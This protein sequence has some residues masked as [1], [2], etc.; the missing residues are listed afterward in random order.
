MFVYLLSSDVEKQAGSFQKRVSGEN[1]TPKLFKE[2]WFDEECE[3]LLQ[4]RQLAY[5]KNSKFSSCQNCSA[6]SKLRSKLS[7]VVKKNKNGF[8]GIVSSL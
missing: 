1:K 4:E 2:T 7:S 3:N 6:Y 5:K 8:L